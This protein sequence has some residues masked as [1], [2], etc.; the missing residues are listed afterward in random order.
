[1]SLERVGPW[2][3]VTYTD[4]KEDGRYGAD[5]RKPPTEDETD[6]GDY[7]RKEEIMI[8]CP[9]TALIDHKRWRCNDNRLLLYY[10]EI[11]KDCK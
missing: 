7:N 11:G 8:A 10:I 9:K 1:M 4:G 2:D 3:N 5:Q 6:Y